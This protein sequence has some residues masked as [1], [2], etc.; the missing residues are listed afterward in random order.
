MGAFGYLIIKEAKQFFGNPF[1][2]MVLILLPLLLMLVVPLAAN[3][4]VRD[5][6]VTVVDRDRSVLSAELTDRMTD[7]A[8]L[9]N[10]AASATAQAMTAAT[11]SFV[12]SR[13]LHFFIHHYMTA[14]A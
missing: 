13:T 1:M 11:M 9:K 2:P 4:E 12:R 14:S 3:M 10:T 8:L 7:V 5:V 6:R